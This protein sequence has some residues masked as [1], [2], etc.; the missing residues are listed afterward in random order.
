[1][2]LFLIVFPIALLL[3]GFP[4]YILLL[5][6]SACVL[7]LFM[8]VP[9]TAVHQTMFGSIDK[10]ALLAVPFFLFAGEIMGVGGMSKRIVDWCMAVIGR[11]RGCQGL[12]TVGAATVF[13]AI[14]GSAAA[15]VAAIGRLMYPSLRATYG[16]KF[17]TGIISATGAIDILIPPSI[18]MILYGAA[19][20][21]SV[22]HLFIAGVFPGLLL[23]ACN[24]GWVM[25]YA[26]RHDIHDTQRISFMDFLR[27]TK[28]GFWSLGAPAVILGGIY[29]G[30]FSPTEAAGIA[31][32]YGIVITKFVYGELTWHDLWNVG[33]NSMYLTAQILI[34]VAGAGVFSWI[35][36]VNGV[37]QAAVEFVRGLADQQWTVLI[38][39]NVFLLVVGCFIDPASAILI[40]TPLLVPIC[41]AFG[42]DLV[43][44]GI[45]MTMNLAIGMFHPPFGLNI[46]VVQAL[47]RA[48]TGAIYLGVIPFVILATIALVIVTYVPWFSLYLTKFI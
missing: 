14:S 25:Y 22:A 28:A 30:I 39:I 1:M 12:T 29:G 4:I 33:V 48:P 11:V 42:I 26:Y 37:P 31:C 27:T 36:T 38:A 5:A 6:T 34:I 45:I 46:F 9:L 41:K 20:E 23:A 8:N 35:L 15:T 21:Q 32:V 24:A 13:G 18:A 17:S 16:L 43:H 19:A 7:T 47:T 44:F 40:L 2:D 10:F 3:L